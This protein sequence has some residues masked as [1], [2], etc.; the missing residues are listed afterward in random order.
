LL[1]TFFVDRWTARESTPEE[2]ISEHGSLSHYMENVHG[3]E[4]V[5][6]LCY[7]LDPGH[8]G[9]SVVNTERETRRYGKFDGTWCIFEIDPSGDVWCIEAGRA[10][11]LW[12]GLCGNLL[13]PN[14]DDSVKDIE[15]GPTIP[16][17]P[18]AQ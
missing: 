2:W 7:E 17:P 1:A 13:S 4:C 5:F 8:T 11:G 9:T 18:E 16:M 10:E 6:D 14:P 12:E 15:W 3:D